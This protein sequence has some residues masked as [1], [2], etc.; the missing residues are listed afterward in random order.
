MHCCVSSAAKEEALIPW[1]RDPFGRP[2]SHEKIEFPWT[3]DLPSSRHHSSDRR[4]LPVILGRVASTDSSSAFKGELCYGRSDQVGQSLVS[5]LRQLAAFPDRSANHRCQMPLRAMPL[6]VRFVPVA[7]V[8]ASPF[9]SLLLGSSLVG[10]LF[11]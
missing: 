1:T 3:T 7:A 6:S 10:L 8:A 9:T 11:G 5:H 4:S 2:Q